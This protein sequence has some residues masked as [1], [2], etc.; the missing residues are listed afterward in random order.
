LVNPSQKRHRAVKRRYSPVQRPNG[1]R[2]RLWALVRLF[3]ISPSAIAK[4]T[5]YSRP[6]VARLLSP[7]D[8]CNGSAEFFRTLEMKLPEV[9]AGRTGLFLTCPAV[10]VQ[11]VRNVLEQ[12]PADEVAL[13]AMVVDWGGAV[14]PEP[15]TKV[16]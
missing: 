14:H 15:Q 1:N 6:Y 9:I 16:S 7:R 8:E 4:A 2:I 11:R 3:K 5:N 10:T 12:M 13:G